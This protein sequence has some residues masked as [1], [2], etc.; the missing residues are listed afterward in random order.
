[1]KKTSVAMKL[2][3]SLISAIVPDSGK[4]KLLSSKGSTP[5]K[6][7]PH[8]GGQECARRLRYGSAAYYSAKTFAK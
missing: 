5:N 6:Y 1:M 7:T 8:Q 2:L 3:L 4:R